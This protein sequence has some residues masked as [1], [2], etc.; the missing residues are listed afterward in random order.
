MCIRDRAKGEFLHYLRIREWQD[1]VSQIRQAAKQVGVKI[2]HTPAEPEAIHQ[3]ILTGLLSHLGLRDA[4]RRDYLGARGARFA[5]WPGSG[6]KGQP[7][8][9]MV[10]ELVETSRLW[11]RTAAKIDPRWVEPLAEHLVRRS[12]EEP[13]WEKKRAS[14]VATERVTLYGLPIVAGRAVAYGAL[15]PVLSRVNVS[16]SGRTRRSSRHQRSKWA[17]EM[18]CSGTRAA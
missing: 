4:A 14:V 11:G 9:V 12:Y 3:A 16:R 13:R 6:L 8:W 5:L 18:I 2:T 10:S 7:N 1:L 17:P 15:D